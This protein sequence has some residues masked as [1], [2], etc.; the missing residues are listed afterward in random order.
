MPHRDRWGYSK[1]LIGL[2]ALWVGLLISNPHHIPHP[3][4]VVGGWGIALIGALVL[5]K[6]ECML[7]YACRAFIVDL[8]Q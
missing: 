8:I 1:D 7:D 5:C 4:R 2:M 3:P 6:P